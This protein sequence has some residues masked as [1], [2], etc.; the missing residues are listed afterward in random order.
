[1]DRTARSRA[2][3][4]DAG[5]R[6]RGRGGAARAPPEP[7]TASRRFG[8]RTRVALFFAGLLLLVNVVVL[9]TQKGPIV[10]AFERDFH[11]RGRE[12]A[13]NLAARARHR[14]DAGGRE[15]LRDLVETFLEFRDVRAAAIVLPDGE[16]RA[17]A[18][19]A[20][21]PP[22]GGR[23]DPGTVAVVEGKET[24]VFLAAVPGTRAVVRL[25]LGRRTLADTIAG[26]GLTIAGIAA[27]AVG[28]GFLLVFVGASVFTRP[29]QLL[30]GL[31]RRIRGGEL[32]AQLELRRSDEVGELA[33]AM[34]AM[35]VELA[36]QDRGLRAA[37][38][39]AESQNEALRRQRGELQM[40]TRN[41]Q[42]LVASIT[43]GVLFLGP[44]L[45]VAIANAAA[46]RILGV[47]ARRLCGV[48][49]AD[50][51]AARGRIASL[52]L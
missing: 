51:R 42:T 47:R 8:L 16:V 41:L 40:Q 15:E 17:G 27:A 4:P 52:A 37:K 48:P 50:V 7:G 34:N 14:L 10:A 1:M 25:H 11:A 5:A 49:L 21:A 38:A 13:L 46:E 29:V 6:R 39:E 43:E 35:S 24:S 22:G 30:A 20:G 45:R 18:P 19:E 12:L 44:D 2:G 28:T 3:P 36:D 23:P 26:I 32:G 9:V 33:T 31:A